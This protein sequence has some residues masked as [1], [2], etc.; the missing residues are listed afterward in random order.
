MCTNIANK[1]ATARAVKFRPS[2]RSALTTTCDGGTALRVGTKMFRRTNICRCII[3]RS[4]NSCRKVSCSATNESICLFMC[5]KTSKTL[6][7]KGMVARGGNR[8]NSLRFAGSCNSRGSAARSIAVGGAVANGRNIGG[9]SFR[10]GI[11]IGNKRKRL[12]GIMIGGGTGT[13]TLAR[14]VADGRTRASCRVS[15]ANSVAVCKLA[16]SS[17]CAM[18]RA[19]TG[20][21]KCAAAVSKRAATAKAGAKAAGRSN[22]M[23][24]CIGRGSTTMMAN[25]TGGCAPCML[26]INTTNTFKSIFFH[27]GET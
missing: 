11:T 9:G 22:A 13:R 2:K 5:G 20:G 21:S 16:R 7:I 14:C 3:A 4:T 10:F 19:S 27:E 1:V 23:I 17:G 26:L 18:A 6:C 12:C 24:R 25:I 15:S 8:G